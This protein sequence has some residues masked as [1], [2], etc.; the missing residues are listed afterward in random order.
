MSR[1]YPRKSGRARDP[2]DAKV[3]GTPDI[4][5]ALSAPNIFGITVNEGLRRKLVNQPIRKTFTP[6]IG[7]ARTE[8]K[9]STLRANA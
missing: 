7:E 8:M 2:T 1:T 5:P 6:K 3:F 9:P 4:L